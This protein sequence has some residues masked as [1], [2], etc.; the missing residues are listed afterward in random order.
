MSA[1]M[2]MQMLMM[3]QKLSKKMGQD[4]DSDD[5]DTGTSFK[6]GEPDFQGIRNLRRRFRMSPEKFVPAFAARTASDLGVRDSRQVWRFADNGKRM[7]GTFGKM[8][9]LHEA[10][11]LVL[12]IV[13]LHHDNQPEMAGALAVQI[14]KALHQVALDKGSWENAT[15]LVPLEEAGER[16]LFGGDERELRGIYKYKKSLRELKSM[17]AKGLPRPEDEEE[18]EEGE[19]KPFK[20]KP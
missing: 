8:A 16:S 6:N 7:R 5:S 11:M 4:S 1:M 15:L 12:E 13:Q 9:G 10:Y 20:K 2:N 14:A 17:G 3:M 18:P 19:K